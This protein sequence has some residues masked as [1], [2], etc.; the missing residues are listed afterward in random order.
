MSCL[1]C[2][3]LVLMA[4]W[5]NVPSPS[6]FASPVKKACALHVI[7]T[8]LGLQL[9]IGAHALGA[10]ILHPSN[11]STRNVFEFRYLRLRCLRSCGGMVDESKLRHKCSLN[12]A[13]RPS[14][15]IFAS[16]C[17]PSFTLSSCGTKLSGLQRF[18][19]PSKCVS[20]KL[21]FVM[22]VKQSILQ[23][24]HFLLQPR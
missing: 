11:S 9:L 8:S 21:P 10:G 3:D 2:Y 15:L 23:S 13:S 1:W 12:C 7:T 16:A 19:L 18:N 24:I 22:H 6:D 4:V 14:I 5:A 17:F 20:R